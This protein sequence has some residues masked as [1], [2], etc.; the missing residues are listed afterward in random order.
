MRLA[1]GNDHLGVCLWGTKRVFDCL[2]II[3]PSGAVYDYVT[4]KTERQIDWDPEAKR[5]WHTTEILANKTTGIVKVA[6]DGKARE[7]YKD[8]LVARRPAGPIGLQLHSGGIKVEFKDISIEVDPR[9]DR[10][11]TVKP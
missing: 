11:L 6:V 7:D 8:G 1:S 2:L 3:P 4:N 5:T 10:L 9:E